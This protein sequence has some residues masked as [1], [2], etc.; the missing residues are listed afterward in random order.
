MIKNAS[1]TLKALFVPEIF[2]SELF[3][4]EEKWFDEKDKVN[5]R[6]FDVTA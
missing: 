4:R 1:F 2:L 6:I 3:G 5:F